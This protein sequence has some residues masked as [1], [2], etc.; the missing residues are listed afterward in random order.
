MFVLRNSCNFDQKDVK[1]S[2]QIKKPKIFFMFIYASH[3]LR[4]QGDIKDPRLGEL[5]VNNIDVA[6]NVQ[7]LGIIKPYLVTYEYM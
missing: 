1:F 2:R 3:R 5:N 4:G 7:T 6:S